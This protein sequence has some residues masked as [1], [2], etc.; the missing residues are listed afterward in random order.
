MASNR[1]IFQKNLL[2]INFFC[3]TYFLWC[4][5]IWEKCRKLFSQIF[6]SNNH[7]IYVK[8]IVRCSVYFAVKCFAKNILSISPCLFVIKFGQIW[9]Y[10]QKSFVNVVKCFTF[11]N[12]LKYFTKIYDDSFLHLVVRLLVRRAVL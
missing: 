7:Y 6:D 11:K 3:L 2:K 5:Q 12:L 10:F 1:V 8:K 4:Y 9:K